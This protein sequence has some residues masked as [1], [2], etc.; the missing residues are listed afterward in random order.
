MVTKKLL[1]CYLIP[2][3]APLSTS[4]QEADPFAIFAVETRPLATIW[5]TDY[6]HSLELGLAYTSDPNVN[7][8]TYSG[9]NDSGVTLLGNLRWYQQ[10]PEQTVT[11]QL[12]DM[13]LDS[14][15]GSAK[16]RFNDTSLWIHLDSTIQTRDNTG[17]TPFIG[18]SRLTL[19]ASWVPGFTTGEF[20]NRQAVSHPF[21]R[22][23]ER[24]KLTLGL[25]KPLSNSW[26][27]KLESS[28]EN[29]T[30]TGD[31]G[32]A[33]YRDAANPL[34]VLLPLPIDY[35]HAEATLDINYSAR[36]LQWSNRIYVSNFANHNTLLQWQNPYS[37]NL[38]SDVD[39]PTGIGAMAL[40]PDNQ[41]TQLRSTAVYLINRDWRIHLDGS[42][43]RARQNDD[44]ANYSVNPAFLVTQ[45]LPRTSLDGERETSTFTAK[46]DG[47]ISRKI[48]ADL[49]YRV[50]SRDN[51][52]PRN[53]YLYIRGDSGNQPDAK[54]TVYNTTHGHSKQTAEANL[55]WRLPKRTRLSA[56]YE[57]E[58]IVR[59]NA[60][61]ESTEEK[62]A[63]LTL[64]LQPFA[65][66][67]ARV[68]LKFS[69]LAADTYHWDQSYFALLDAALINETPDGERYLNHPLLS[70]YH[71]SNRESFEAK[72]HLSQTMTQNWQTAF[73][74][75]LRQ[76]DYDKSVL[77]LTW[78]E[79]FH[80][81][82]SLSYFTENALQLS[83]YL[84][85]DTINSE[86]SGR[87][88]TGGIEKNAFDRY[89]PIAQAADPSRNWYVKS[90]NQSTTAGLNLAW[91]PANKW[92]LKMDYQFV[93]SQTD[94]GVSNGGANDLSATPFPQNSSR[95]H[96]FTLSGEYALHNNLSIKTEYQ[97]YRDSGQNWSRDAILA[98]SI[99]KV[100]TF[101]DVQPNEVIHY[102]STSV[103][104]RW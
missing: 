31:I 35:R 52:I 92:Q 64:A 68:A 83:F 21:T 38:G 45:S 20:T 27:L 37:A 77:G 87:A 43:G 90:K 89:S 95:M 102:I 12:N 22:A 69:D 59:E 98:N 28:L 70:Q 88:F 79:F 101:G 56:N 96:H 5:Q 80:A 6:S 1:Y 55:H 49:R 36:T 66:T 15:S 74:F 53:H 85:Y 29:K 51:Q 44:F 23:T 72:M 14:R 11:V 99:D 61:V 25:A 48:S 16:W 60:A 33:I 73:D 63:G 103:I 32:A 24:Q 13:G 3:L 71:L 47:R 91:T 19:P 26:S 50:L 39:Y 54:F 18:E 62:R 34:A 42:F 81:N 100:L 104:Y 9:L 2:I 97:Y 65:T 67:K 46:V 76:A 41:Y 75:M 30:G 86:Q 8:G 7:F 78:Q 94:D 10:K 4:A 84:S 93:D 57:F 82:W 58:R 17:N 40:A